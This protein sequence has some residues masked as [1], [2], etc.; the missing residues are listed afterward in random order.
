MELAIDGFMKRWKM[1]N[2]SKAK[3]ETKAANSVSQEEKGTDAEEEKAMCA[4]E[5]HWCV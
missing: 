4:M 3:K 1:K 5:W 2:G